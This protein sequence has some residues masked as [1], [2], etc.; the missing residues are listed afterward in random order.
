IRKGIEDAKL[1]RAEANREPDR[2]LTLALRGGQGALEELRHFGFLAGLRLQADEQT[3]PD[4]GLL[5]F[6]QGGQAVALAA[7]ASRSAGGAAACLLRAS[8]LAACF[9]FFLG[10]C[11]F[12]SACAFFSASFCRGRPRTRSPFLGFSHQ[13]AS[14]GFPLATFSTSMRTMEPFLK[15]RS[16]CA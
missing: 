10:A 16:A 14:A 8:F 15:S 3:Q 12:S 1:A 9:F 6:S 4:H 2:R 5:L 7:A 11:S 13:R